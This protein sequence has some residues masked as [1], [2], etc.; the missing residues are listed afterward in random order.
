MGQEQVTLHTQT[1]T[2]S[3]YRVLGYGAGTGYFT[4]TDT[5]RLAR[6]ECWV[7]GQEQVTL[8]THTQASPYRVLG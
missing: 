7:R 3:P 2:A 6:T 8:Q 1:H 4:H 5:H